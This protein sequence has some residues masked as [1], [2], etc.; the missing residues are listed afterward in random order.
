M[1]HPE[2]KYFCSAPYNCILT[3]SKHFYVIDSYLE[4]NKYWQKIFL[5]FAVE[6]Y[7]DKTHFCSTPYNSFFTEKNL[8]HRIVSLIWS[9]LTENF[10]VLCIRIYL[11]RKHFCSM[12]YNR[13]LS[14][15]ISVLCHIIVFCHKT[16][17]FY[18]IES[19]LVIIHVCCMP[20][21]IVYC[22]CII[23]QYYLTYKMWLQWNVT[24]ND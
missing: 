17:L 24:K 7:L 21:R 9:I 4:Y 6:L 20:Y 2:R 1:K 8:R 10:S 3:V 5:F 11:E 22:H 18:A 13:I 19:C 12:R 14:E 16:F 23:G 15:N